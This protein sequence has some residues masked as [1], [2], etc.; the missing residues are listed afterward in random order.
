MAKYGIFIFLC[1][2]MIAAAAEEERA[3]EGPRPGEIWR[4]PYTGMEFVWIEGGSFQMHYF[5]GMHEKITGKA[6]PWTNVAGFWMGKTEVTQ[7]QWEKATGNNPSYFK[8]ENRPVEMVSWTAVQRFIEILNRRDKGAI[9]RLPTSAE[10]EYAARAGVKTIFHTGK[11]IHTDQA[12]YNGNYDYN[13][14]DCP[15]T[16]VYRRQTT[17]VGSFAPNAFGLYDMHGNVEEWTCSERS[18]EETRCSNEKPDK[19]RRLIRGGSWF[20]KPEKLLLSA[21]GAGWP[22]GTRDTNLGFRLIR[23]DKAE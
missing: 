21:S 5:M 7:R 18:R 9:Y 14:G 12:N 20:D 23:L 13:Y 15:K 2:L 17:D 19:G 6:L 22:P 3:A 1:S 4:E 16:G 11:C 8:G 10:R